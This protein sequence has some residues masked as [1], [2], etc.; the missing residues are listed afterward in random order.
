[1]TF[2]QP[3]F[4]SIATDAN[5]I[6]KPVWKQ[7]FDRVQTILSAVMGN[8]ATTDRPNKYA[9]IGQ[10]Y[11]DTDLGQPVFWNGTTWVTWSGPAAQKAYGQFYDNSDQYAANTTT[12]YPV[13]LDTIDGHYNVTVVAL[14]RITFDVAGVYNCQFSIQFV[15]TENNANQPSEVNIW[16]RLNGVDIIES[17]SQYTI[18]NKHG[19]HDGKLIAALNFIQAV[20]AGDYIELIWQ[21]ENTNISIQTLPAGTTPTTPV[22]PSVIFTAI[23]I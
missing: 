17:N 6:M 23:Q 9:F 16:F 15:S 14:T 18:P 22:T 2:P 4:Q 20:N 13:E 11:F 8:G 1:M 3:P 21:T 12:A 10:P 5:G 7:W 19:S